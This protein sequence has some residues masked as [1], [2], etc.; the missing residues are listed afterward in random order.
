MAVA[1]VCVGALAALLRGVSTPGSAEVVLERLRAAGL[2]TTPAELDRWYETPPDNQNLALPVLEAAQALR[3]PSMTDTNVPWLGRAEVP[4][5]GLPLDERL[6]TRIEGLVHTNGAALALARSAI[7]RPRCR[8]PVPLS[9]GAETPIRH[10]GPVRQLVKT[11]NL[12]TLLAADQNR[13]D[14]AVSN[15]VTVLRLCDSLAQEP[16][17]ISVNVSLGLYPEVVQATE[18]LLSRCAL[19]E[20]QL[21][22]VESAWSRS[23]THPMAERVLLSQ[24]ALYQPVQHLGVRDALRW[25]DIHSGSDRQGFWE[26]TRLASYVLSGGL[27]HEYA[28]LVEFW[29]AGRKQVRTPFPRRL[30]EERQFAAQ[31]EPRVG[32]ERLPVLKVLGHPAM[33]TRAEL[34]A[35]ALRQCV[36]ASCAV[37]RYRL[38]HAGEIP[39]RLADLVPEPCPAVPE[40]PVDGKPLQYRRSGLDY[41]IYSVG[42]DGVDHGGLA[43]R[44][45][46]LG[47][48][49]KGVDWPIFVRRTGATGL[50]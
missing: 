12:E 1:I 16:I 11:L 27:K 31:W 13:A 29:D 4:M 48:N 34:R 40:D 45:R 42:E 50:E 21:D 25:I 37:E 14:L 17:G 39:E 38:R 41:V 22:V 35:Q 6:R 32:A 49:P 44:P 47:G 18:R 8:Y 46:R 36:L 26:E 28:V 5:P 30:Q 15:L 20:A 24:I 19:T 2:P 3:V 9:M 10:L 7:D 23:L 43:P 33:F